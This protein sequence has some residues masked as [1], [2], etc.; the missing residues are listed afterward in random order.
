MSQSIVPGV[1]KPVNCIG[2]LS[3][4]QT[5][6]PHYIVAAA[7]LLSRASLHDPRPFYSLPTAARKV[8]ER[9]PPRAA[10]RYDDFKRTGVSSRSPLVFSQPS[11]GSLYVAGDWFKRMKLLELICPITRSECMVEFRWIEW[12]LLVVMG[13]LKKFK[14]EIEFFNT[15]KIDKIMVMLYENY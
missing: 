8:S 15:V 9:N 14:A 4:Y 3:R 2:L 7:R 5:G 10:S 6:R 13:C 1:K 12:L 11:I